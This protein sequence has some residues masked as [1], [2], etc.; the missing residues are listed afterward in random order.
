MTQV[1][2]APWRM[3]YILGEKVEGC[4]FCTKP[5][6]QQ[7]AK[8]YIVWRGSHAFIIFNRYPYN[9]G[10]LMIVPYAHVASLSALAAVQQAELMELTTRCE[11]ILTRVLRPQ[12]FNIGIN[13]GTAAGAGIAEHLHLH[14]VPRW[15]GDTNYMTVVGDVRVIPQHLD[16]TYQMLA[17]HFHA[18]LPS[19]SSA[20]KS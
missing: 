10:H 19:P 20:G 5:Q 6:E 17:P 2:W 9:N 12:G 16:E 3:E 14:I 13:L 11:H 1:L 4:I 18:A 15:A 8:N 7:D